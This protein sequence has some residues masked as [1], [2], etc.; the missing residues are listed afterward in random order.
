[1]ELLLDMAQ[2]VLMGFVVF[3]A[4]AAHLGAHDVGPWPQFKGTFSS[5]DTSSV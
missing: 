2:K 5:Y 4:E 1:M 3:G